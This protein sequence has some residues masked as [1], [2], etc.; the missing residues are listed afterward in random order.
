MKKKKLIFIL[1]FILL[2]FCS[3]S[4]FADWD[5]VAGGYISEIQFIGDDG[6]AVLSEGLVMHTQDGGTTW[7]YQE[8]NTTERLYDV[9]FIDN[10]EGWVA[11]NDGLIF[12]TTDGGNSWTSQNSTTTTNLQSIIFVDALNGWAAGS[13][14]TIVHTSDGGINWTAQTS[15]ISSKIYSI[16]FIDDLN[17]WAVSAS[18]YI[19]HTSDGGTTW[20]TQTNPTTDSMKD[21]IFYDV[22]EGWAAGQHSILHTVDGG[23]IWVEQTNPGDENLYGIG[24]GDNNHLWAVGIDGEILATTDGGATWVE[25]SFALDWLLGAHFVNDLTGWIV[26]SGGV[27]Y[28]TT[29]GGLN[30]IAQRAGTSSGLRR[31]VFVDE[32]NVWGCGTKGFIIHSDDGGLTWEGKDSGFDDWIWDI[33]FAPDLLHGWAAGDDQAGQTPILAT[34]DGGET[35]TQQLTGIYEDVIGIEAVS[36]TEVFAAA[37][38]GYILHTTDGGAIWNQQTSGVTVD[39]KSIEM[40]SEDI[41]W[42][43]GVD[44]TILYTDNGGTTWMQQTSGTTET[45]YDISFVDSQNGWAAGNSGTMLNT[46]D[47][48]ATW[49]QQPVGT[50]DGFNRVSAISLDE[51][52]AIADEGFHTTDGGLTWNSVPIPCSIGLWGLDFAN[53]NLGIAMGN[54]GIIA[55]YTSEELS[56]PENVQVDP[57]TGALTWDAPG[58]VIFSDNFDSY[59]AGDFLC[60][61]STDWFTW[62]NSPGGSDDCYVVDIQSNSP[63]NSIEITGA[64]DIIHPFGDL[65]TGSYSVNFMMYIEPTYGGYFNL[66]H[67]F[68]EW[69]RVRTEWALE[70]YFG[71]TG[72]GTLSAGGTNAA[73]FTHP[74]GSWFE[75]E[76]LI[77]LDTDL[78]EFYVDGVF[79]HTWQWSL[80]S[81]GTPGLCQL[82]AID[83]FAAA[84][85]GDT[86]L[87]Y[88]D[89]FTHTIADVTT[90]DLSGYNIYLDDMN[91]PFATV[92]IDVFEYIYSD[93]IPAQEY[94][95]GVSAVYDDPGESVIIEVPFTYNPIFN[96]PQNLAV[97][98]IEDYA[99]F[100]W[101]VPAEEMRDLTGY[102]VYLDQV[103]VVSNIAELEYDF[104]GLVNGE[105]YDA[106]VRAI[107]DDPGESELVEINFLYTGTGAENILPLITELTGNYPN[108]FNPTTTISFSTKEAGHVSI[109]IYNMRGQLVNTLVNEELERDFHVIIWDGKDNNNKAVSSGIYFYKMNSKN[110][111]STRKMILLK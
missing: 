98:C 30:W 5:F 100:T 44:G 92:G 76:T 32:N 83:I 49:T 63:S 39:F 31:T 74:V 62:G 90:R 94:L 48:G 55:R 65:I 69:R 91:T 45:I 22:N 9:S 107:Y 71:S 82:G 15:G 85:A 101:D 1:S 12:H 38:D 66:L 110:Y 51:V 79:I 58:G 54:G 104:Y 59:A 41:G 26:G 75:V 53:S 29:D 89:D 42:V 33:T 60:T 50:T 2:T 77:D 46:S 67:E 37:K 10:L 25:Q 43:V 93:L 13:Y 102:N 56:P 6:W 57:A 106:G 21:I 8:T 95:A 35:W 68:T 14:G 16:F 34:V 17:G 88:I 99:H 36:N 18:D 73:T 81:T 11:G 111:S 86:P 96:P 3:L 52:W 87:F 23:T 61:Q 64:S 7:E 47:G 20:T 28:K 109:S 105:Y 19:I 80:Q 4:L 70:A 97:E 72:S 103:E 40:V 108:P 24:M 84:P 27:V 78:A